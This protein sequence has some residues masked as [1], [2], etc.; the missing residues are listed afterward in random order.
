[1]HFYMRLNKLLGITMANPKLIEDFKYLRDHCINVV[2]AYYTYISLFNEENRDLLTKVA[3]T[4]FSDIADIMQRDW[5]LQ[6]CKLM[7]PPSTVRKGVTLENI[8]IKL[9]N[10]QLDAAGLL[11]PSI[12]VLAD[13]L[14]LYGEKIKPARD[15]RLAHFDREH[16]INGLVL[17]ATT[18]QELDQFLQNL[19][20]YCDEAGIAIGLG[21]LAFGGGGCKGDVLDLLRVLRGSENA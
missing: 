21:P 1:M 17:G 3:S 7:D 13:A 19:Q 11:S 5:I 8:S 20:K 15:K 4:F 2:Y 9:I 12:R 14:L 16:Q 10:E 18:E 6:T